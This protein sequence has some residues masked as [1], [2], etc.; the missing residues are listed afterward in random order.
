[1]NVMSVGSVRAFDTMLALNLLHPLLQ[2]KDLGMA[3][4]LYTDMPFHKNLEQN[5]ANRYNARDTYGALWLGLVLYKKLIEQRMYDLFC[6]VVMPQVDVIISLV[7]SGGLLANCE[8][9]QHS[10]ARYNKLSRLSGNEELKPI[11]E[12]LKSESM[13][14]SRVNA[15]GRIPLDYMIHRNPYGFIEA[16]PSIF[17][18]AKPQLIN[19]RNL[20]SAN[21]NSVLVEVTVS[22]MNK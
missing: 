20:V 19:P 8:Y 18:D 16:K 7:N 13:V 4:S 21:Q 12:A 14:A 22:N 2:H 1:M 3:L 15:N 6:D 9:V 10:I 5:D 17:T 11:I